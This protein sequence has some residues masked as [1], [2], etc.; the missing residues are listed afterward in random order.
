MACMPI[1]PVRTG[2]LVAEAVVDRDG[3]LLMAV[4]I[5]A[6]VLGVDLVGDVVVDVVVGE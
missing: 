2:G 6:V 3:W 5:A 4:A 1:C